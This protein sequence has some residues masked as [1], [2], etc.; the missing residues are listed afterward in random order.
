MI[1][2]YMIFVTLCSVVFFS[3]CADG[4][5]SVQAVEKEVRIITLSGFLTELIFELGY[6]E[7]IVGRDV[8]STYPDKVNTIPSLGHVRQLNAEAILGLNPQFIFLEEK[9]AESIQ[10]LEQLKQSGVKIVIIPTRLNFDNAVHASR[11]IQKDLDIETKKISKIAAKLEADSIQLEKFRETITRKP[12]VLFLYARGAGN[13]MAGGS[14]TSAS[15]MI[16]KAGARNAMSSFENFRAVTAESLFQAAP[17]V[18]LMF[19]GGLKSLNDG[20]GLVSVPGMSQTPAFKSNHIIEMD[21]HYLTSF[22]PRSAEAALE[23]SKKIFK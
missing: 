19:S 16:E 12:S 3:A 8:T 10:F 18:I 23:L 21:G 22:G 6:G 20:T 4:N 5:S 13:V 14:N 11:L 15:V 17:D 1:K 7:N 9:Q 2:S